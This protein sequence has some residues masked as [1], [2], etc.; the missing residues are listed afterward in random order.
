MRVGISTFGGDG[1]KSGISQ[2]IINILREMAGIRPPRT[3]LEVLLC[4]SEK[5]VFLPEESPLVPRVFGESLRKPAWSVLWHQTALPGWCRRNQYDVLFLP[6]GNRRLPFHA[7]C[8]TVGTV[9]D[10]SSIH[11]KGKYGPLRMFYI[12]KVLPYLVR[13]LTRVI[14]VS[15][16]SKRD[17]VEYAGVP[18]EKVHVTPLAANTAVFHPR[19]REECRN[20][21]DAKYR[22]GGPYILYISRIEHPGKN[23]VQLIEAFNRLKARVDLPHKLVLAGSDWDRAEEVH[24]YAAA[25]PRAREIVFTGFVPSAD[26]PLLLGACDAFVFPSLFE[27]FGLPVLEALA[28]GIPTACSNVSSMP[29]VAG[30]AAVLFDPHDPDSIARSLERLLT[31]DTFRAEHVRRGLERSRQFTWT[32]TAQQTMEVLREAAREVTA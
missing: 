16:C 13:K 1:G 24:A 9:H 18:P 25:S 17:I 29:E 30:D 5:S 20:A 11:V 31:E 12:T 8:P 19:E 26:L 32:R 2:Y 28:S 14:T 6:A 21:I 23:H 10:F 3:D 22:I 7:P 4:G 15:E 27:G